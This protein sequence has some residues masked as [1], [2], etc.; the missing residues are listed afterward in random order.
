M[1]PFFE[2]GLYWC[3]IGVRGIQNEM[4]KLRDHKLG[5]HS[6][7]AIRGLFHGKIAHIRPR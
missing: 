2:G 5:N 1:G 4:P 6:W 7:Q 3:S